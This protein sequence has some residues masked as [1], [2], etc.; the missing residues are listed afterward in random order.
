MESSKIKNLNPKLHHINFEVRNRPV[1]NL[2]I[3][4][5]ILISPLLFCAFSAYIIDNAQINPYYVANRAGFF[6]FPCFLFFIIFSFLAVKAYRL[7]KR[8]LH[9]PLKALKDTRQPILYLR[10]F[11][12]QYEEIYER[13]DGKTPEEMLVSSLKNIGPVITVGQPGESG[14]PY[15]GATRIYFDA[16]WQANVEKLMSVSKL[17][18]FDADITENL[19][20]ELKSSKERLKPNQLI[21]TFFSKHQVGAFEYSYQHSFAK[22]FKE[23]F[24]ND[25]PEY[26]KNIFFLFFDPNWKPYSAIVEPKI[27]KWSLRFPYRFTEIKHFRFFQISNALTEILSYYGFYSK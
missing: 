20:W 21:I 18:V 10:S 13:W 17:V 1:K 24:S 4:L 9:N 14:L 15:L 6:G 5:L 3:G 12:G 16:D 25:L 22:K 2:M 19:L 7:S 11:D 23:I 26:E 27:G 8:Y